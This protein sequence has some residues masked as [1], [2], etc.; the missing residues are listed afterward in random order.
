TLAERSGELLECAPAS[1]RDLRRVRWRKCIV[2]GPREQDVRAPVQLAAAVAE[3]RVRR[4][5]IAL[6]LN[7][8]PGLFERLAHRAVHDV[9]ARLDAAAGRA[10][11]A[12]GELR[13]ANQR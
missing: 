3:D 11:H 5:E 12:V 1:G 10:P 13:L 2:S 7:V 4:N 8:Q 9:L 6:E